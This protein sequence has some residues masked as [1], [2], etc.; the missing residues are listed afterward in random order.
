MD[1][2]DRLRG[3]ASEEVSCEPPVLAAGVRAESTW[4]AVM[5]L[6]PEFQM[7]TPRRTRIRR[8]ASDPRLVGTEQGWGQLLC[9]CPRGLLQGGS[10]VG[11][12]ESS[13]ITL[14][15][16]H[17][18]KNL[19]FS[20]PRLRPLRLP[21]PHGVEEGRQTSCSLEEGFQGSSGLKPQRWSVKSQ[22][23][24]RNHVVA[25]TASLLKHVAV[26]RV[27]HAGSTGDARAQPGPVLPPGSGFP[28]L[29]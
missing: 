23:L 1:I 28:R 21:V 24:Q 26:A 15:T 4:A 10:V 12:F 11:P 6:E 8:L 13:F 25:R 2:L 27:S 18:R 14:G 9:S 20:G 16:L 5:V 7:G 3:W 29:V 19:T 17:F 22:G